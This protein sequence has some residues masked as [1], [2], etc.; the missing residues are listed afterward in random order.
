MCGCRQEEPPIYQGPGTRCQIALSRVSKVSPCANTVF[1]CE[2]T[3]QQTPTIWSLCFVTCN[4]GLLSVLWQ[5]IPRI[6]CIFDSM[7]NSIFSGFTQALYFSTL[8]EY[9]PVM[10]LYTSTPLQLKENIVLFTS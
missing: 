3:L 8:L 1:R 2:V 10:L 7:L 9:F 5:H 6:N 4:V